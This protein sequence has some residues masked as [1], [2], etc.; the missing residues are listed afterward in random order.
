MPLTSVPIR[1]PCTVT[2]P[3]ALSTRTPV[4]L[5]ETTFARSAPIDV[6]VAAV[7]DMNADRV[8]D[9]AVPLM[10]T[11]TQLPLI[12][13]PVAPSTRMPSVWPPMTFVLPGEVPPTAFV[14]ECR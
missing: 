12:S 13:V 3:V 2:V 5:P 6:A 1:F 7:D 14:D 10:L 4:V 9:R 8:R 11:P